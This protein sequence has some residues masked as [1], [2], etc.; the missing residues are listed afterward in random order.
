MS[1]PYKALGVERNASPEAIKSAYRKLAK[2]YHPDL[3]PGDAKVEQQFKDVSQA[4]SIL[5]DPEKRKRF[6]K[7]EIDASGQNTGWGNRGFYR[8]Y[9]ES[10]EGAKYRTY[11]FG[12]GDDAEDIFSDLFG[13]GARKRPKATGTGL[14]QPNRNG[15]R[16]KSNMAGSS[17]V[18][19]GSTWRSGLKLTRPRR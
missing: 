7:G 16:I 10:G 2:K 9:A 17:T 1:D 14:A 18:P 4:Y 8:A 5:S 15:A 13:R 6:D 12:L 11:D 19:K 3:N